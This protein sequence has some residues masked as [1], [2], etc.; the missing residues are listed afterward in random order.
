[1][2][3]PPPLELPL[4]IV[5]RSRV[6]TGSSPD[7]LLS[8]STLSVALPSI[9]TWVWSVPRMVKE[10]PLLAI[11]SEPPLRLMARLGLL[12][13]PGSNSIMSAAGLAL[14][15]AIAVRRE[16]GPALSWLVTRDRGH[17][18]ESNWGRGFGKGQRLDWPGKGG[19]RQ[20]Q[21]IASYCRRFPDI[22][23]DG[24]QKY[25]YLL[26]CPEPSVVS[27]VAA[28]LLLLTPSSALRQ[29]CKIGPIQQCWSHSLDRH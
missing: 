6:I 25:H 29:W 5:S 16:P 22:A 9:I 11:T 4:R 17:N 21:R 28:F 7:E 19:D 15:V 24:R 14:A 3:P 23:T 1:M 26:R 13:T 10:P 20:D 18:T 8:S 2:P 27:S 12:N